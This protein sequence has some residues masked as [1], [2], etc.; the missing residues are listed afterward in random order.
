MYVIDIYA[1]Y[2]KVVVSFQLRTGIIINGH[3]QA[4][5]GP[6]VIKK[7]MLNSAKHGIF[8]AYDV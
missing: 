8:P 1:H 5:P 4:S 6:E 3:L 7:F 2:Q